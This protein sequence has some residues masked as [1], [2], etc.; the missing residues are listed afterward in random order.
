MTIWHAVMAITLTIS[1][2]TLAIVLTI[3]TIDSVGTGVSIGTRVS[4]LNPRHPRRV[5]MVGVRV[6]L[7]SSGSGLTRVHVVAV[8]VV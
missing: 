4:V 6:V 7:I 1:T 5:I 8:H 3:V 2:I